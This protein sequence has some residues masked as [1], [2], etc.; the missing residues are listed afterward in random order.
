[1]KDIKF[2]Q[3]ELNSIENLKLEIDTQKLTKQ[4]VDK[5]EDGKIDQNL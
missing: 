2:I 1:M 3:S 5:N 4:K